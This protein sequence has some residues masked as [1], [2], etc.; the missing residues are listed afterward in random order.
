MPEN[1][2]PINIKSKRGESMKINSIERN[3]QIPEVNS[4]IK[5]PW[6][7][8]KVGDSVLFKPEN[9]ET[10]CN[11]KRKISP[12]ARYYGEK[13]GKQYKTLIDHGVNGVRVW[14]VN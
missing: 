1:F 3:I 13:T 5:Y 9:G 7:G 14:R 8:M 11:I 6:S 2:Q 12:A 10:L 4:K